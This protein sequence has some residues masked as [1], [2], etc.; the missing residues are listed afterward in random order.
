LSRILS[1]ALAQPA[2]RQLLAEKFDG[3]WK[4]LEKTI[5]EYAEMR[6]DRALMELATQLRSLDDAEGLNDYLRQVG[7][8]PF[9]SVI[10][11]DGTPADLREKRLDPWF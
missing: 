9:G 8:H 5:H 4:Y 7:Q 3:H 6:A 2:A 11:T 10:Q 1:Y